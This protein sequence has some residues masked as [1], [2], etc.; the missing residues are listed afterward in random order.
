MCVCKYICVCVYICVC[1]Y[2]Y[3][4][5]YIYCSAIKKTEIMNSIFSNMGGPRDF[6]L[7]ELSQK[8]KGKYHITYMWNLKKCYK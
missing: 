3:V 5:M 7:S 2:I 6:I 8:E 4:C 1:I